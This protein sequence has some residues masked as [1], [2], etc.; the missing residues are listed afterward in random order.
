TTKE[1]QTP[2]NN[3]AAA[4]AT[5]IQQVNPD[6][7]VINEITNNLQEGVST[8]LNNVEAFIENYLKQPQQD[9]LP[10]LDYPY[11]Y[12]ASSNTG[13]PSGFDLNND[14]KVD[15]TPGD[16]S[17]GDDAFGFGQYPGQYA[18]A[19]LSK[20]PIKE[21]QV[22]TFRNFLWKDMPQNKIPEEYYSPEELEVLRLSSKSHWDI[23]VEIGEEI[24]HVLVAHPTPP[25][26]D[27]PENRNGRRNHD[28]VRLIA[29]YISG[30]EY[31]YD[32][33]GT[34]GGLPE[35]AKFVVM[36]DMNANPGEKDNYDAASLLLDHPLI[37]STVLPVSQGGIMKGTPYNTSSG[38]QIDYVLPSTNLDLLGS[39]VFWPG[40]G[41][42]ALELT[43]SVRQASD[44]YLVWA[45]IGLP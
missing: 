24:I 8:D 10:G 43:N 3:Q 22:R 7:L 38:L 29:D 18:M 1:V 6:V 4:A 42:G 36:G 35:G 17:Y 27:G 19:L 23:P 16:D 21:E 9:G 12:F 26:F 33:S 11:I 37:N 44:H 13:V 41:P 31:I 14:G 20:Y 2:G 15:G 34:S 40:V 25:V 28:E 45:E 39:A 5:I 32:D 30:S